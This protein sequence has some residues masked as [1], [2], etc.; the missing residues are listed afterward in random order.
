MEFRRTTLS[1]T[2][3]LRVL[4]SFVSGIASGYIAVVL[5]G[6]S[7]SEADLAFSTALLC[8]ANRAL[9]LVWRCRS[10]SLLEADQTFCETH[11]HLRILRILENIME[12]Q[13]G[14]LRN[15]VE[16]SEYAKD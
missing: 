10:S 9:F 13:A 8:W 15:G 7:G 11:L 4:C 2:N 6:P 12:L 5:L 1:M 16:R 14:R 3:G